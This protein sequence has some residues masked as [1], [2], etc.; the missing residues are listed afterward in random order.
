MDND[1]D[2]KKNIELI[3]KRVKWGCLT[4]AAILLLGPIFIFIGVFSYEMFF[5][6][7]TLV[8]SLSPNGTSTIKVVEKG[9]P[10]WFGP[11][12]VRIKYGWKHID[13]S[14]SND[15]KILLES[16]IAI[17]WDVDTEATITIFGEEQQPEIIRF[18]AKDST[19]FQ[20]GESE[21]GGS[22]IELGSFTFKTRE[23]PNLIN[24]IEFR[25]VSK[26]KGS[27]QYSTV[28]IFYGE[29]GSILE[30]FKEY[31]PSDSYTPDN[32]MVYWKNDEQVKID[33]ITE[34]DRGETYI[35]DTIDIDLTE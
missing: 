1:K 24:I 27:T 17:H 32:F 15:G 13:R 29:R 11:S 12:S 9:Q 5:K 2:S 20:V 26:S 21:Q 22:E 34:N 35:E 7:K 31:I 33:V 25:E 6:E 19:P 3:K 18:N 30:K 16:N 10:A 14:V 4:W 28:K 23:S 8:T